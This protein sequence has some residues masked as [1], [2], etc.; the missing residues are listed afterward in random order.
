MGSGVL[1]MFLHIMAD[2]IM[3]RDIW[4]IAF[5]NP[6]SFT[7]YTHEACNKGNTSLCGCYQNGPRYT[8]F[9][10]ISGLIRNKTRCNT[11]ER[12]DMAIWLHDLQDGV[13]FIVMSNSLLLWVMILLKI[14]AFKGL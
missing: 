14:F 11:L 13:Y 12:L 10:S 7:I 6:L 9:G 1:A 2:Q 4:Y 3:Y 5:H 8:F